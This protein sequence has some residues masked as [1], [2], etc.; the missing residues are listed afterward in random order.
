MK[1]KNSLLEVWERAIAQ[2]AVEAC[3]KKGLDFYHLNVTQQNYQLELA[4]KTL[5]DYL[6]TQGIV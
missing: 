3:I 2:E 5:R 6:A 4:K 1:K